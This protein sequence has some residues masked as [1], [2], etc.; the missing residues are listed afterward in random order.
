MKVVL[1]FV[2]LA[3][4]AALVISSSFSASASS[5]TEVFR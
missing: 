1:A 3:L 4:L 2:G 5:I